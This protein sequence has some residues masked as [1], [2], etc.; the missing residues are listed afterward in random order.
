MSKRAILTR[1][2]IPTLLI[3]GLIVFLRNNPRESATELILAQQHIDFG[4]LPEWEGPVTRSVTARNVGKNTLRIQSIHTGCSYAKITGP[5]QIRPNEAAAFHISI[6]PEILS[7]DQT[8]ATATIFTDSPK[9][10]SVALTIVATAKRFATLNPD[11]C[12]FGDILPETTHQQQLKLSVN[13]PLNTSDIRLLPSNHP[14]LTW[15]MAPDPNTD[16]SFLMTV[17]LGPLKDRGHFSSLLTVAFPN[18]RTLTLPI[19][20]E[21]IAPVTADPQ[22]LSYRVAVSGTQPALEFTL[23]AETPFEVL[24]V[25]A[26]TALDVSI[27]HNTDEQH[28][29]RLK[30]VWHVPNSPEPLREEI[31]ILTTADPLPI[32][33]PVYGSVQLRTAN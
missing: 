3:S 4:V 9:T 31:Q 27:M 26:P 29:K 15:E 28:Q 2:I 16:T 25:E 33:I 6:N 18:E 24:K 8:S 22:T 21:V 7:A 14:R 11:I 12:D 20:A 10:P 5:E 19:T 32:R 17:Q 23:S 13:A 30:V 1:I